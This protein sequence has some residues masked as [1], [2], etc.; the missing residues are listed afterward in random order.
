MWFLRPQKRFE[1]HQSSPESSCWLLHAAKHFINVFPVFTLCQ[2]CNIRIDEMD[3]NDPPCLCQCIPGRTSS[4][5]VFQDSPEL[6][7][8][9]IFPFQQGWFIKCQTKFGLVWILSSDFSFK[10]IQKSEQHILCSSWKWSFLVVATANAPKS[11][12]KVPNLSPMEPPG[13]QAAA[14]LVLVSWLQ[15]FSSSPLTAD[16]QQFPSNELLLNCSVC[17]PMVAVSWW[18][19]GALS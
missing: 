1:H 5:G 3:K 7:Y 6:T 13:S 14:V 17:N 8:T 12:Y 19:R 11:A 10:H 18:P 15:T 2:A 9:Y 16:A 4:I